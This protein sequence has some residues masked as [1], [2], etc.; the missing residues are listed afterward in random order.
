MI[1]VQLYVGCVITDNGY[2]S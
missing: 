2:L 1:N